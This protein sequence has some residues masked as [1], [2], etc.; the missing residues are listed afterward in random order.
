MADEF[1]KEEASNDV[2]NPRDNLEPRPR[3]S[4]SRRDDPNDR[5][6]ITEGT[7]PNAVIGHSATTG[8]PLTKAQV[9][10]E[11]SSMLEVDKASQHNDPGPDPD[12]TATVAGQPQ[13]PRLSPSAQHDAFGRSLG[14]AD[15]AEPQLTPAEAAR[16]E[17][18]AEN[19]RIEERLKEPDPYEPE[20]VTGSGWHDENAGYNPAIVPEASAEDRGERG[21]GQTS[22]AS[23]EPSSMII[24]PRDPDETGP[25]Q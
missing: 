1:S 16:D 9:F 18:L 7:G 6:E 19:L 14:P 5:Q 21:T 4:P 13:E 25:E 2:V 20:T 23:E 24:K 3:P 15:Y 22:P 12:S 8:E 10:P 17:S 11:G